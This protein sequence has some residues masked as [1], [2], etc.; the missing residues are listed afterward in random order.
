MRKHTTSQGDMWDTISLR[1]YGTEKAMA[2]LIDANPSHRETTI[3]SGGIVLDIPD[4]DTTTINMKLP[5]WKRKK[6]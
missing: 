1:Y 5:P 2:S 4:L 6:L 3:F